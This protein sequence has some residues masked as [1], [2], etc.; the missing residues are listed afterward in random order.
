MSNVSTAKVQASH[1]LR[2]LTIALLLLGAW[3]VIALVSASPVIGYAN[4]YDMARTSACLDFWPKTEQP[5]LAHVTAPLQHYQIRELGRDGCYVSSEVWIDRLALIAAQW[6]ASG[7]DQTIDLRWIGGS[8]ALLLLAA[9]WL[10]HWQL[11]R[12]GATR[13]AAFFHAT[14]FAVVLSDPL[15]T[16]YLNT[17]YTEFVAALAC[18]L[19]LGL[20]FA[21]LQP[22]T[23]KSS[24]LS[25]ITITVA[26]L[27]LSCSRVPNAAVASLLVIPAMLYLARTWLLRMMWLAAVL[28]GVGLATHQQA[29]FQQISV[30]NA[31]N[32][33]LFSA[34]PSTTDPTALVKALDLPVI[35]AQLDFTSA[36][37]QRGT[38]NLQS[39]L[40]NDGFSRFKLLRY[41]LTHPSDAARFVLRGMVQ[42]QAWRLGYVGEV[43]GADFGKATQWSLASWP[44]KLTPAVYVSL[45]SA[46][47][48]WLLI[49]IYQHRQAPAICWLLVS[50]LILITA[51]V[52][53]ALIGDGY[54]EFPRH[55]HLACLAISVAALLLIADMLLRVRDQWRV[56]LANIAALVCGLALMLFWQRQLPL[57]ISSFSQAKFFGVDQQMIDVDGWVLDPFG[58]S[59][60][61]TIDNQARVTQL[62]RGDHY[63]SVY[64]IFPGYALAEY[65]RIVG[66]VPVATQWIEIRV[67][68]RLGVETVVDRMWLRSLV[69]E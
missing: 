65:R 64:A 34:L 60:V 23:A 1:L 44:A 9:M 27:L 63:A 66:Q 17:L 36:Y 20:G 54:S 3:R 38:D 50:L 42:S 21:H 25:A 58:S 67:R 24:R 29:Q 41:W 19:L 32:T 28:T 47:L 62:Q 35:C 49:A 40:G 6:L 2:Y 61:F 4:Q 46:I 37:V 43:A 30:T 8:K 68:N 45:I 18:Y 52:A 5:A 12:G 69:S 31:A 39:C 7:H 59:T 15:L 26:L 14:V 11:T 51:P 56:A 48:L 16:L 10:I 22:A 53:I 13:Y 55:A 33:L 57:A